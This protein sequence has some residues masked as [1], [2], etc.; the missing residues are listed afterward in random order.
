MVPLRCSS[1]SAPQDGGSEQL[2][3]MLALAKLLTAG[4]STAFTRRLKVSY[5]TKAASKLCR[6]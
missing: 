3:A 4:A 6:Q 1:P 2:D 5:M